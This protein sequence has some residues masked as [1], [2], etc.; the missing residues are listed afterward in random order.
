MKQ[1]QTNRKRNVSEQQKQS[2]PCNPHSSRTNE[3]EF[4]FKG[5]DAEKKV[6]ARKKYICMENLERIRSYT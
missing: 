1:R 6:K 3:Q 2:P 4:F 5:I